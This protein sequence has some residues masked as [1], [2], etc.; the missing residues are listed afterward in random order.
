MDNKDLIIEALRQR[1]GELTTDYETKIAMLRV[2]ITNLSSSLDELSK[3]D[4]D[5]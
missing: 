3:E 1:I 2:E 4:N 5:Q